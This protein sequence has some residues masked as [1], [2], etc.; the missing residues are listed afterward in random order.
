MSVCEGD[1]VKAMSRDIS[2]HK[3]LGV[4]GGILD[5]ISENRLGNI[6]VSGKYFQE[7]SL[8]GKEEDRIGHR[9]LNCYEHE[10]KASA[11]PPANCGAGLALHN[12]ATMKS[13][14][15][16]FVSLRQPVTGFSTLWEEP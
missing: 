3:G 1:V 2:P 13:K 10:G 4:M 6:R 7:I 11:S 5:R 9:K 12:Y 8:Q 16:A 15:L 14:H